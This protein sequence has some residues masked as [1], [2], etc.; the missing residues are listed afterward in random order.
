[1]VIPRREEPAD[2]FDDD[3]EGT[4]LDDDPARATG[5]PEIA[6]VVASC[7]ASGEAVRLARDAASDARNKAAPWSAVEG[8]HIAPDSCRSHETRFNLRDQS[9]DGE[10]FPLHVHD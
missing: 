9:R 6:L 7:P 10:G 5:G 3:D 2:V 4:S 1:L 8:S